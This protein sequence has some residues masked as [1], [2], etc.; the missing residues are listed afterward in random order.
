MGLD[1]ALLVTTVAVTDLDGAKAFFGDR[2]GLRV[3]DEAPFA[4]RFGAG[5]GSQ[6]SVRRGQPNLGQTV[7]HFEVQDIEATVRELIAR[8]VTFNDYESPKTVDHIAQ[9]GP[10]RGAWF[11]DPDGNV[12]GLREGPV[13][14]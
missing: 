6:V 3:L 8:G 2:L 12:F 4:I 9:I 14:G 5:G 1:E 13:P 10:A 7:G 11:S